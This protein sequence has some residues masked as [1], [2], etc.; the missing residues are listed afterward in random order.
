M[1]G[2][3]DLVTLE[4]GEHLKLRYGLLTHPGNAKEGKVAEYFERFAKLE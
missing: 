3:T 1:K 4:K 2:R